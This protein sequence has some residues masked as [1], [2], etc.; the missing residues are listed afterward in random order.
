MRSSKSNTPEAKQSPLAQPIR[1][2]KGVG[3]KLGM[4]FAKKDI[5]TVQD[6][7]YFLPR[8]YEDRRKVIKVS[9]CAAHE[10]QTVVVIGKI[11]RSHPVFYSRTKR[12]TFEC[13]LEDPEGSLGTLKLTWFHSPYI[14]KK[15]EE[16]TL[17][18]VSGEVTNFRG[19]LQM[20]HPDLEIAG[21]TESEDLHKRAI[22]PVYSETSGLY[23]KTLR[24]ILQGTAR[25]YAREI[26]DFL[27]EELRLQNSWPRLSEAL[28]SLHCPSELADYEALMAGTSSAHQRL[29]Y[30]EFFKLSLS[31]ALRKQEVTEKPGIAFPKPEKFWKIF[32]ENLEFQ[33][34]SAQRNV[35]HDILEDMTSTRVMHR[36]VQGDVG[37]GK[38]VVAAAAA[39]V[40][41]EANYQVALMAPTEIL[42]EQHF[43]NFQKWF[44]DMGLRCDILT[45]S[46]K[47]NARKV[48]LEDLA[49]GKIHMVFGTHALFEADVAF[50]NLGLVIVDEQHRFGVRQRAALT[51][52]AISPDLL[53]MTA[54]PIPRTLAL[55]VYGD[56]DLSVIDELPPGR[57]PIET[58]VFT[59][60]QRDLLYDL[61]KAQIA[62]GRQVYIVF[63]L[64]DESEGLSLRSLQE[65]L[66][67]LQQVFGQTK[68]AALHGRMKGPE[69]QEILDRFRRNE[70]QILASTTV[71]EV[72]VDVPNAT[73]MVIENA[74]RFGLSQ[75]HQLRGRVGR[76]AHKSFCYLL[77]SHLGTPEII[78]RLRSMEQTQDGFKLS[79]VDLEMRGPGEILGTR[80]S[81]EPL[82]ELARLPRDLNLL[83]KARQ[84]AEAILRKDSSLKSFPEL[85]TFLKNRLEKVVLN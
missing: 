26:Q 67:E 22:F 9:E 44:K 59:S 13:W 4:L 2:V 16:D 23:Q 40:A 71:V 14:A 24:K 28:L 49:A 21:K 46:L 18:V 56:L 78:K 74:E 19:Q 75:L 39:L 10:N 3:E 35:L 34:T 36:L 8:T 60:A 83:Q 68:M 53:V 48:L 61:L 7:L 82:F 27:P 32:K 15:L 12:K 51:Q 38:T 31:L 76:G 65:A 17:V 64:I 37:S 20:V 52:K 11:R 70:I 47:G 66:P 84:D 45:G 77:A 58:K 30:D 57:K 25:T 55:T 42:A 50:Q 69:K 80:Q 81:G 73:V 41:L 43:R 85:K 33:F 62:E 63:P 79:E 72:G 1:F 54:T 29:I 5:F 6:L